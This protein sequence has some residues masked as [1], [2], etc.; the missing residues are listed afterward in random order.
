VQEEL[1]R[2]SCTISLDLKW[3]ASALVL[4]NHGRASGTI[5]NNS[6]ALN[7]VVSSLN[8]NIKLCY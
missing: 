6:I 7:K 4:L 8:N 3:E 2:I 5:I 1:V